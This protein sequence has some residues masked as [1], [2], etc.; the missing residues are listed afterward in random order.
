MT[1]QVWYHSNCY[2]GFGAAW[3]AQ[4]FLAEIVGP[5]NLIILPVSYAD[6]SYPA[7]GPNEEVYMVDFSY[8]RDKI[9]EI[10][11][12]VSELTILDHH[13]TAKE[14]LAGIDQQLDNVEV[15]FDMDRSGAVITWEYFTEEVVPPFFLYLQDHDLWNKSLKGIDEFSAALRSYSMKYEDWGNFIDKGMGGVRELIEEGKHIL[16]FQ[17]RQIEM[18]CEK[19]YFRSFEKEGAYCYKNIPVVNTSFAWSE[20]GHHMLDIFPNAPFV[21][22]YTDLGYGRRMW[23]LRSE[24]NRMDVGKVAETL[25]KHM[26]NKPGGGHRNAAGFTEIDG[27]RSYKI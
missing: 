22:S 4:E 20:V 25:G 6:D 17:Q 21:A 5:Q 18:T 12:K 1:I 7:V 16:R 26:G 15:V 23:S 19:A 2:D 24:D 27:S 10:A 11:S 13:K 9:I 8:K 3:A 14:E